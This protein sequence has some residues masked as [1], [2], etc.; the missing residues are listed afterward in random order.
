MFK[1]LTKRKINKLKVKVSI[2]TE[3]SEF[4]SEYV[5][6]NT[7]IYFIKRHERYLHKLAKAKKELE[8]LQGGVTQCY[9]TEV[10]QE[11]NAKSRLAP[12]KI[13]YLRF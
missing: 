12:P 7:N 3:L 11:I 1:F 2:Y 8:I 13:R 10:S 6:G 4:S 9:Q 5:K